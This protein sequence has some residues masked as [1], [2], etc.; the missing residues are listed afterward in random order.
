METEELN[1]DLQQHGADSAPTPEA[2]AFSD[3]P[4]AEPDAGVGTGPD[5]SGTTDPDDAPAPSPL[6]PGGVRFKQVYARA[7]DAETKLQELREEKARLEGQLEATRTQAPL[8]EPKPEPRLAWTQL[9]AGIA[10]GKITQAQALEY[11]DETLRQEFTRKLHEERTTRDRHSTV[12]GELAQYKTLAPEILS[13]GTPE[14]KRVEQEFTYLVSLGYDAK[15]LR[16]E[17]LA[18]RTA[19]GDITSLKAKQSASQIPAGRTTMQDM[20]ANGKPKPDAKDPLKAISGEQR[21]YYQRMIDR[22]HYKGW[23]QVR[24]EL[25]FTPKR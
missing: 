9:E 17:L 3:E 21:Q 8:P 14:R 22:G 16:T 23:A 4:P 15:D 24:E 1:A 5:T 6:E 13:G 12:S 20:A 11:R 25:T 10:E 2:S 7:K 18:C 19:L